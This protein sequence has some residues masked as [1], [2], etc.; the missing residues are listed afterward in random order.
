MKY[1]S[2]HK[3]TNEYMGSAD[4]RDNPRE[5]DKH[6]LP[7]FATFTAP[8]ETGENE[9]SVFDV[10]GQSWSVQRDYR[11]EIYYSTESGE[12]I[13]IEVIGVEP[14]NT[15]TLLAPLSDHH[16]W[17]GENWVLSLATAKELKLAE[18]ASRRYEVE[19]GGIEV[20]G[21]F[22]KTDDRTKT[23]I[24]G[25]YSTAMAGEVSDTINYKIDHNTWI[26][27]T[28]GQVISIALAISA[29]VQA[30]FSAEKVH[31]DAIAA[32]ENVDAVEAYDITTGWLNVM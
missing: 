4:A 22:I 11:G 21:Q 20:D 16:E 17:D 5:K 28:N 14:D 30:C 3:E 19:V 6:L 23:L 7:A 13:T 27:L 24:N 18:L 8:P 15:M 29:F 12:K 25:A 2:Y 9:V 10:D 32:L 26:S 1:Y 31:A